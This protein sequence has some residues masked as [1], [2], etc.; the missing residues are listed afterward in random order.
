MNFLQ[1]LKRIL[2][3]PAQEWPRIERESLSTRA[4]WT[5]YI[6]VLAAIPA[7]AGFILRSLPVPVPGIIGMAERIP[8]GRGLLGMLAG[9]LVTLL[10]I[11]FMAHIANVLARTHD[12]KKNPAM[13][14]ALIAYSSTAW[15]LGN[16]FAAIPGLWIVNLVASLYSVRLLALGIPVLMKS[17]PEKTLSYTVALMICGLLAV[18]LAELAS[19][20]FR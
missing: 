6:L 12:A 9:Y 13:A 7:L 4:L 8:P 10:M 2:L 16:V 11:H 5:R 19:S 14:L 1:R 20:L 3:T 17:P 18:T 15:M